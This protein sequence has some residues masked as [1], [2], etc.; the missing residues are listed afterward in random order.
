LFGDATGHVN[1]VAGDGSATAASVDGHVQGQSTSGYFVNPGIH[2]QT[3]ASAD[4]ASA[5]VELRSYDTATD[6]GY[7]GDAYTSD[8]ADLSDTLTYAI[9]GANGATVTPI[10]VSLTITGTMGRTGTATDG[11]SDGEFSG[12]L[13]FGPDTDQNSASFDLQNNGATGFATM[14][15]LGGSDTSGWTVNAA[16][17]VFTYSETYDLVGAGGQ[18]PIALTDQLNCLDGEACAYTATIG[19]SG[20]GDFSYTSASGV[21]LTAS[22]AAPEPASWALMLL[23]VAGVGAGLRGR[24]QRPA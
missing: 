6:N 13:I 5:T 18:L 21:F 9:A 15:S 22:S 20:P 17:T 24:R 8:Q 10:T 2:I 3:S 19:V 23:G 4:L 14:A 7:T 12:A 16:D 11:N 1:P